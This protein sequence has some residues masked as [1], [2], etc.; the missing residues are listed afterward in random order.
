MAVSP[1][2][3]EMEKLPLT[4]QD[5]EDE[6]N[7]GS[8][9][10]SASATTPQSTSQTQVASSPQRTSPTLPP[11]A[12][13]VEEVRD[14]LRELLITKHSFTP[15]RTEEIAVTWG[16][17]RGWTLR[18]LSLE[19]FNKHFG[20][21]IGTHIYLAVHYAKEDEIFVNKLA[22]MEAWKNS[23]KSRDYRCK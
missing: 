9:S 2:D 14:Y 18:A 5:I 17:G 22:K 7:S 1:E 15:E 12:A 8:S 3:R 20:D 4:I 16:I 10:S 19:N 21:R 6:A 13:S 11:P 23:T